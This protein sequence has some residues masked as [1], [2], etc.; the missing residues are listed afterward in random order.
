MVLA[1][2]GVVCID[3]FDKM[4]DADRVAIHEVMEQQTVT[5]AKAGIHASLNARCSVVAAANPIYGNYDHSQGVTRNINLPDSLLSRFDMLFIVLDQ[6]NTQIDRQISSHVLTLHSRENQTLSARCIL[7]QEA[8]LVRTVEDHAVP[9]Y[10][11]DNA[12]G[13]I[14]SKR[15]LQKYLYYAKHRPWQPVL[16]SAAEIYI[17]DRYAQW[18]V[19]KAV[20]SRNRRTIPITARTLETM[21]RLSTAHAKMRMSKSIDIV[22][23]A[24]ATDIMR[25]VVEADGFADQ[26]LALLD[27]N[28]LEK[29]RKGP[30]SIDDTPCPP[31]ASVNVSKFPTL[32]KHF[33][34]VMFNRDS[35]EIKELYQQCQSLDHHIKFTSQDVEA[36]VRQMQRENKIMLHDDVI[37]II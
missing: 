3:E 14:L 34:A 36:L 30:A 6:S 29:I 23:A 27:D 18:R 9:M 20:D 15:F 5:I 19:S 33:Q 24:V 7:E 35:I 8:S 12:G 37:H 16:T 25:L 10:T 1:D 26:S 4:N 13:E 11:S 2:R 28:P 21:I 32:Q 22:D 17:A 31:D